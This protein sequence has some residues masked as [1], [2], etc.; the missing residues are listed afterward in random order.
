MQGKHLPLNLLCT[1]IL[2]VFNHVLSFFVNKFDEHFLSDNT[3]Y[4]I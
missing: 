2:L 1:E 3:L 4:Q